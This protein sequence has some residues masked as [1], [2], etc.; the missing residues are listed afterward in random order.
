[1]GK[2]GKEREG[3]VRG[4]V[5]FLDCACFLV[6]LFFVY[7]RHVSEPMPAEVRPH[8][9]TRSTHRDRNVSSGSLAARIVSRCI[10]F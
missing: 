8:S 3:G 5:S 9:L 1:M 6:S 2:R 10:E 7:L 4:L